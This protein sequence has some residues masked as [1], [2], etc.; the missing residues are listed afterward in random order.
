M[1]RLL[2]ALLWVLHWLPLPLLAALAEGDTLVGV[3]DLDSP[4]PARF[5]VEDQRGLEAVAR[6][7]LEALP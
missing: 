1:S 7:Y 6:I 4:E 2:V 3:F 5:D